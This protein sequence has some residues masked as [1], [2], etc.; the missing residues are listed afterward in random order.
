MSI[1]VAFLAAST[2]GHAILCAYL[3]WRNPMPA[4]RVVQIYFA[5][6]WFAWVANSLGLMFGLWAFPS[7]VL[8]VFGTMLIYNAILF[9]IKVVTIILFWGA[10]WRL[11]AA[12]IVAL[13]LSCVIGEAIALH[14]SSLIVYLHWNLYLTFVAFCLTYMLFCRAFASKPRRY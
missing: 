10:S 8:G 13:S 4:G 2:I 7:P 3:Y 14:Y 1:D 6:S 11:N 9:P 5:S 12:G